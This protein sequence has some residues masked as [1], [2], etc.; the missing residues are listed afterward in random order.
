MQQTW[1]V[2]VGPQLTDDGIKT[3]STVAAYQMTSAIG[4]KSTNYQKLDSFNY[5]FHEFTAGFFFVV[6]AA[7]A[8]DVWTS[9]KHSLISLIT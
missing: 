5:I 9:N 2:A 4:I 3:F 7:A 8:A 6:A 1:F